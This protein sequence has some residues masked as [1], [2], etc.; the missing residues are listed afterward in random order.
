MEVLNHLGHSISYNNVCSIETA[1]AQ[2]AQI[3][4]NKNKALPLK[5]AMPVDT[6]LTHLWVDNFD[7]NMERMGGSGAINTTHLVAFINSSCAKVKTKNIRFFCC[8]QVVIRKHGPPQ[9]SQ[10]KIHLP[11]M[12]VSF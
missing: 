10:Y 5:P 11:L 2:K 7:L 1:Q 12:I 4:V 6:I 8:N 9:I 3:L